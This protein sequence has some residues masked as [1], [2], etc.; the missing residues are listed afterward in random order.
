[1]PPL[2]AEARHAGVAGVVLPAPWWGTPADG[3]ETGT[4][5]GAW[6]P[7]AAA[8]MAARARG[9]YCGVLIDPD[10][11]VVDGDRLTPVRQQQQR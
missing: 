1:M 7:Y 5:H 3:G 9:A 10:G 4:K 6:G 2:P 8:M 11:V